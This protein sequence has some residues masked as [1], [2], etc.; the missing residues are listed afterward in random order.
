MPNPKVHI[1]ISPIA[2]A[3]DALSALLLILSW[4]YLLFNYAGIP[5]IIPTH[6]N[7]EGVADKSGDKI[8]LLVLVGVGS[9]IYIALYI[10]NFFPH[11]M[12]HLATITENNAFYQYSIAKNMFRLINL[13]V[14]I[15]FSYLSSKSVNN[16]LNGKTDLD[17]WMTPITLIVIFVPLAYC[18]FKLVRK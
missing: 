1:P 11:K 15:T 17:A 5:E 14:A 7:F 18:L 12:N 3:I 16:A 9:V 6:Y 13:A 10:L 4:G 2:H 8:Q